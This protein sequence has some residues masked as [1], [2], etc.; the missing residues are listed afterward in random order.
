MSWMERVEGGALRAWSGAAQLRVG[1]AALDVLFEPP[2]VVSVSL[3]TVPLVGVP[4][5]PCIE[6]RG[7]D[8]DGQCRWTWEL[9]D[10]AGGWRRV[11]FTR[12]Y[13]PPENPT[14]GEKET[15]SK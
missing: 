13:V 4:I 12:E 15:E 14:A 10:A 7:C 11:G 3:P 9:G 2:E 1:G 6:T 8:D 5:T